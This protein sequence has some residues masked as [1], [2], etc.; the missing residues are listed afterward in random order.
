[1]FQIVCR[2]SSDLYPVLAAGW[3][4]KG[5]IQREIYVLNLSLQSHDDVRKYFSDKTWLDIV[6]KLPKYMLNLKINSVCNNL[7]DL[8]G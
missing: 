3:S 5:H 8:L 1:M 4:Y 7:Q 6:T 2:F